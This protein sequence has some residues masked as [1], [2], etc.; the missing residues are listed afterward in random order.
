MRPPWLPG[1]AG[2]LASTELTHQQ[3]QSLQLHTAYVTLWVRQRAQT[4]TLI[5]S[6]QEQSPA[7][8]SAASMT[9]IS[10]KAWAL[11]EL[12][13]AGRVCWVTYILGDL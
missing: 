11:W 7:P 13:G 1:H 8:L 12:L 5:S 3:K 4:C 9:Q 2:G 10:S 6:N